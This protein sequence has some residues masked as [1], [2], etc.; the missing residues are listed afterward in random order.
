M[1]LIYMS[2]GTDV[3]QLN[4]ATDITSKLQGENH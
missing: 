4:N 1:P 3:M 2:V